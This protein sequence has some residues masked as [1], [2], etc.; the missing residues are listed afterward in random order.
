MNILKKRQLGIFRIPILM[1]ISGRLVAE[2]PGDGV[3]CISTLQ[4]HYAN[5]TFAEKSKHDRIFQ[6]VTHKGV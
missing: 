1:S 5:M 2:L 4:S 6:Q 3:K